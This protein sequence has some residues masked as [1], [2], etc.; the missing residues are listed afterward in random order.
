MFADRERV[1]YRP[2][3]RNF[4]HAVADPHQRIYEATS[5]PSGK[6]TVVYTTTRLVNETL[7]DPAYRDTEDCSAIRQRC[8]AGAKKT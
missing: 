5:V 7:M 3:E 8:C 6:S 2:G 1:S 4:L